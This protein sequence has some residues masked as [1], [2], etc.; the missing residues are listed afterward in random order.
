MK[1]HRNLIILLLAI[2]AVGCGSKPKKKSTGDKILQQD[3]ASVGLWAV[4]GDS[5]SQKIS[6]FD[7]AKGGAEKRTIEAPSTDT[8]L[9]GDSSQLFVLSRFGTFSISRFGDATGAL[10]DETKLAKLEA[11]DPN[12]QE[13]LVDAKGKIWVTDLFANSVRVYKNGLG[14][15]PE[16]IDLSLMAAEEADKLAE[17]KPLALTIDGYVI[18]GGQMLQQNTDWEVQNYSRIAWIDATTLKVLHIQTVPVPNL[19]KIIPLSSGK[20]L[21]VGSGLQKMGGTNGATMELTYQVKDDA[22]IVTPSAPVSLE[23][24]VMDVAYS[25]TT[26]KTYFLIWETKEAKEARYCVKSENLEIVCSPDF[27]ST[28]LIHKDRAYVGMSGVKTS[29]VWIL[30]LSAEPPKLLRKVSLSAHL[31]SLS[32]GP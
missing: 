11:K 24:K 31:Y 29:E 14:S 27:L 10:K 8:V 6:R 4:T 22:V 1:F 21:V 17:I 19:N 15:A 18:V 32:F 20:L 3:S 13:V 26:K 16:T 30:D 28:I 12:P 9:S 5:T 7:L 23:G 2:F 25:N